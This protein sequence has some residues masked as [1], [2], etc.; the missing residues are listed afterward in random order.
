MA[1]RI[2]KSIDLKAPVERVWRALADPAEFGA[3]FRV[4]LDGPFVPGEITRGRMTYPGF[5]H[6]PWESKTVA[7]EEPHYL[8]FR[9][10]PYYGETEADTSGDAWPLVE[11]RLEPAAG[12]MRFTLIESGFDALP[13]DRRLIALRN[14]EGGW[15]EQMRNIK[16]HVD[17]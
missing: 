4:K 5:E 16:A 17:G 6:H 3:W 8:A 14:N 10:P 2:E 7:M 9:W 1:E 11:F 12:G 15:E 13:E